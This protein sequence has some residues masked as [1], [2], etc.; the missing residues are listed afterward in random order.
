MERV[1]SQLKINKKD[2]K[3]NLKVS[4]LEILLLYKHSSIN[5]NKENIIHKIKAKNEHMNEKMAE[6]QADTVISWHLGSNC[7]GISRENEFSTREIAN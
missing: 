6:I 2:K 5:C 4:T 1:F 7:L 3:T